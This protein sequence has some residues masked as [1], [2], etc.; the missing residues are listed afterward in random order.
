[1]DV[2]PGQGSWLEPH[3]EA[4]LVL[5][6]Q[7]GETPAYFELMRAYQQPLWRVCL[8]L[9]RDRHDAEQMLHD[10]A[11]RAQRS[12]RQI[13]AGQPFFPWLV[14][15]ARALAIAQARR[16][17]GEPAFLASVK[18]PNGE[19]WDTGAAGAY[20]MAYEQ[21]VLFAFGDLSVDE[22]LMLALRL[23][24]RLPYS[25]IASALDLPMSATM[26]RIAAARE[27][28]EQA[29]RPGGKAA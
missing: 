5:A 7:R 4:A 16:R 6:A 10:A 22:Q 24:E 21:R 18:R 15:L 13:P 9:T 29:A 8:T 2:R 14:R 27:R 3:R 12:L 19:S 17:E 23:F 20:H 1:M 26:H 11:R 28:L 25:E